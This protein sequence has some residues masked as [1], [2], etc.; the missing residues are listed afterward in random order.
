MR[1]R[2]RRIVA[3][4]AAAFLVLTALTACTPAIEGI[5][6]LTVDADGRPLAALAW[7]ADEPPDVIVLATANAVSPTPSG[8]PAPSA[9][10]PSWPG[11]DYDV[12][13]DVTSPT[14]VQLPGFPPDPA[15]DR[16]AAFRMYGVADN[17][18][19]TTH[20]VTFRLPELAGLRP[21]SVLITT[22]VRNDEVPR[23]V[24]LDEFARL[25]S[26]EC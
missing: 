1:A 21:G 25:G 13:R 17:S 16:R 19:F 9:N 12:P 4:L 23:Y 11:R 8:A 18:S 22:V 26:D 14:T 15:P 24:S 5:T 10:W 20:A 3:T 6:G 2:T 7:C